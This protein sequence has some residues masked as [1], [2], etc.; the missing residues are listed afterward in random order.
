[1]NDQKVIFKKLLD[2]L[3]D[4]KEWLSNRDK[5]WIFKFLDF[6]QE[7]GFVTWRQLSVLVDI[8]KQLDHKKLVYSEVEDI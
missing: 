8:K 3:Q 7:N 5:E 6:Y 1:M 2:G 4:D